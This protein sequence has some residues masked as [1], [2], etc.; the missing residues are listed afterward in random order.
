MFDRWRQV[1]S[2]RRDMPPDTAAVARWCAARFLRYTSLGPQRF[3]LSGRLRDREW[4]A[5]CQPSSWPYIE[6]LE[7]RVRVDLGLPPAGR[8]VLMSAALRRLLEA[9]AD[10]FY[11]ETV[12][13]VQTSVQ[14]VPEEVRWL[15]QLPEARWKG[16]DPRFWTRYSVLCDAS[17]LAR[18]WLD[19]E[20]QDT[21]LTGDDH[22]A[23]QVPLLVMLQ[24]GKCY[25]R[26]QVNP[27]AQQ[28]D[29]VL[30]LELLEQLSARAMALAARSGVVDQAAFSSRG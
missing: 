6:G 24:R 7:L 14:V 12:Q 3:E 27:H 10:A 17:D 19:E 18:L 26:L 30:A 16:P 4:R 28:A 22:V 23:A 9:R 25:L 29:A 13:D 20:A 5:Q 11:R 15:S 21:L 8:V 1:L 2:P